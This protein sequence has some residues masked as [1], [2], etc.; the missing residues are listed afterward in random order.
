MTSTSDDDVIRILFG[1]NLEYGQRFSKVYNERYNFE[2]YT[3]S[4][5]HLFFN[6]LKA[7]AWGHIILEMKRI[8]VRFDTEEYSHDQY[9]EYLRRKLTGFVFNE[10]MR[11][12]S[13]DL[14]KTPPDP[15]SSA[16]KKD[17]WSQHLMVLT[18]D[19]DEQ[20]A[21]LSKMYH[22]NDASLKG[23]LSAEFKLFEVL[24]E[25]KKESPRIYREDMTKTY[26]GKKKS[27]PHSS[28]QPSGQKSPLPEQS[29]P[30]EPVSEPTI[31]PSIPTSSPTVEPAPVPTPSSNTF[32]DDLKGEEASEE[33]IIFKNS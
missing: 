19:A 23:T 7:R 21:V 32:P 10:V 9:K 4:Y 33:N 3:A 18:V 17:Y 30:V 20:D 29:E 26:F 5:V 8:F 2:D 14:N 12:M 11:P 31:M 13:T 15:R 28:H 1:E 25:V 27:P 16:V 6:S 22:W 24:N